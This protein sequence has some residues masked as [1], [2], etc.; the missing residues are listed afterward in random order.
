MRSKP[1]VFSALAEAPTFPATAG[2]TR[3]NLISMT[4]I[5]A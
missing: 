3:T 4:V 2:E 5:V 1:M